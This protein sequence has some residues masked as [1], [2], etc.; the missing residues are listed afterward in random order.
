MDEDAALIRCLDEIL[1]SQFE[2]ED[3][4]SSKE[5]I[6][7]FQIE[8]SFTDED[9]SLI[10]ANFPY[11]ST[12]TGIFLL[13]QS[14]IPL[15][16]TTLDVIEKDQIQQSEQ[17]KSSSKHKKSSKMEKDQTQDDEI[18]KKLDESGILIDFDGLKFSF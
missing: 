1:E 15:C 8:Y 13:K 14:K 16:E 6:N 4:E 17:A 11:E 18:N 2:F 12:D 3:A 9:E 7:K 5:G 10:L